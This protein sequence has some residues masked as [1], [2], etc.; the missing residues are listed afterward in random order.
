[1]LFVRFLFVAGDGI[2]HHRQESEE[3]KV[4]E[5][6]CFP[7]CSP[8]AATVSAIQKPSSTVPKAFFFVI[9]RF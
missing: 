6:P 4:L 2:P 1:L 9:F 3:W 8:R 5:T 7:V